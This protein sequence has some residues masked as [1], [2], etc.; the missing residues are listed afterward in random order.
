MSGLMKAKAAVANHYYTHISTISAEENQ[1]SR[2]NRYYKWVP[3][4]RLLGDEDDSSIERDALTNRNRLR[5]YAELANILARASESGAAEIDLSVASSAE[6]SAALLQS[7]RDPRVHLAAQGVPDLSVIADATEVADSPSAL[8][9]LPGAMSPV[10][11]LAGQSSPI[12]TPTKRLTDSLVVVGDVANINFGPS[13]PSFT[14]A[15]WLKPPVNAGEIQ[16]S[17]NVS[18]A[19]RRRS[20]PLAR[21][22]HK[23]KIRK[24]S[25]SPQKSSLE[26][27]E[28]PAKDF[29]DSTMTLADDT[30]DNSIVAGVVPAAATAATT[31][32]TAAAAALT[33]PI[34]TPKKIRGIV[35]V[36]MRKSL[37]IFAHKASP[38]INGKP[39]MQELARIAGSRCDGG[40][41]V[42][43]FQENGRL[44]VRFKLPTEYASMF[45]ES[46]GADESQFLSSPDV[47][48]SPPLRMKN[49]PGVAE[50][51]T[52]SQSPLNMPCSLPALHSSP[53]KGDRTIPVSDFNLSSPAGNGAASTP[54]D[55][56]AEKGNAA[57]SKR[58][59]FSSPLAVQKQ[60]A[61]EATQANAD[62]DVTSSKPVDESPGREY[63][64]EFI[65]RSKPK[66]SATTT[67]A[68]T[69]AKPRLPLE[70]KSPNAESVQRP[71]RKLDEED[72]ESEKHEDG[73]AAKGRA[74]SVARTPEAMPPKEKQSVDLA[75]LTTTTED[76]SDE[77]ADKEAENDNE[78]HD[79]ERNEADPDPDADELGAE[80]AMTPATRRSSRLRGKSSS[81]AA[82]SSIPTPVRVG[83]GKAAALRPYPTDTCEYETQ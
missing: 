23:A 65:K 36:D 45:P 52:E 53:C 25:M 76:A 11:R 10:K 79:E 73:A 58:S 33:S 62:A 38:R 16:R 40:A 46:Q 32:T 54:T 15:S 56:D 49:S 57:R 59:R 12:R 80:F 78:P 51:P 69:A 20:E 55:E 82:K 60:P 71:K 50:T 81:T 83:R 64:R 31:T 1:Q 30:P 37:D 77:E 4:K 29:P 26:G 19:L 42:M 18:N 17:K 75:A 28:S 48:D 72:F 74:S 68:S 34:S 61:G 7:G 47:S 27:A 8:P 2:E 13:S 43:V 66:A 24:R 44:V 39:A 41:N 14:H 5:T 63:M 22:L 21:S 67:T 70:A 6:A 3:R 9:K 35:D